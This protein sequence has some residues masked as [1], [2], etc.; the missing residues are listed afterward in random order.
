[1][2]GDAAE[3]IAGVLALMTESERKRFEDDYSHFRSYSNVPPW[4]DE[5]WTRWAFWSGG[6]YRVRRDK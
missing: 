2:C 6:N 1:M 5:S 3:M 4:V